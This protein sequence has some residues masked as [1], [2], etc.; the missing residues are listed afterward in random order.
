[1]NSTYPNILF[2]FPNKQWARVGALFI[3]VFL[4]IGYLTISVAVFFWATPVFMFPTDFF[5]YLANY[6]AVARVLAV[7]RTL[8]S[9]KAT[10]RTELTKTKGRSK[11]LKRFFPW[12]SLSI[13]LLLLAF[14]W[15][16]DVYPL[17][18]PGRD[19]SDPC[20]P[21]HCT[22]KDAGL[23]LD[24]WS[25]SASFDLFDMSMRQ[26]TDHLRFQQVPGQK[27]TDP[28]TL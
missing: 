2:F 17:G 16:L 12:Y 5:G 21:C 18:G 22:R 7:C 4:D 27:A 3:D 10:S 20:L 19:A 8:D 25:Y 26:D 15:S 1:M 14:V 28:G 24:T 11:R 13:L 9:L 23:H 6:M